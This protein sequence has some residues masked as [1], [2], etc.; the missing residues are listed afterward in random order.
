MIPVP[1][2]PVSMKLSSRNIYFRH[3]NIPSTSC[4]ALYLSIVFVKTRRNSNSLTPRDQWCR[5]LWSHEP[6]K[7]WPHC[8][9]TITAERYSAELLC[10]APPWR[11]VGTLDADVND[12]A[13]HQKAF[14]SHNSIVLIPTDTSSVLSSSSSWFFH[15]HP[16]FEN[17]NYEHF[18]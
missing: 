1:A 7:Y 18:K 5:H 4:P 14:D 8:I 15:P 9:L 12:S 6:V 13:S 2:E 3:C 10:N 16:T 17:T 11:A